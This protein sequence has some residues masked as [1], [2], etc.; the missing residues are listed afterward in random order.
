MHVLIHSGFTLINNESIEG[1]SSHL[2]RRHR[3]RNVQVAAVVGGGEQRHTLRRFDVLSRVLCE[4]YF[5][6][7][8]KCM[9][10]LIRQVRRF[11]VLSR[12]L[13]GR[14][15]E[16]GDDIQIR[17][18]ATFLIRQLNT[19]PVARKSAVAISKLGNWPPS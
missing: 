15:E 6:V 18:L 11:D 4:R 13:S 9:T 10:F 2:D 17:Q 19:C 14:E 8:S 7:R 16:R 3:H 12:V 5:Q 1:W